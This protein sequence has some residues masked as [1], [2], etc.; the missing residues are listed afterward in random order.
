MKVK[1]TA[2][3]KTK[4]KDIFDLSGEG[5]RRLSGILA[6]LRCEDVGIEDS[7][8][9]SDN[10]ATFAETKKLVKKMKKTEL[11]WYKKL[12]GVGKYRPKPDPN[13]PK[14]CSKCGHYPPVHQGSNFPSRMDTY[15]QAPSIMDVIRDHEMRAAYANDTR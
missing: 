13:A 12:A 14:R 8:L 11:E 15:Q 6:Y 1:K 9:F 4:K 5:P 7:N 10:K 3:R 2:K